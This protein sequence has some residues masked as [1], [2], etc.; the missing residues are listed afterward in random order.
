MDDQIIY[1][2]EMAQIVVLHVNLNSQI[3]QLTKAL[4][5][6]RVQL[7]ESQKTLGEV[8]DPEESQK[9]RERRR[10][11]MNHREM[12]QTEN[13]R[14]ALMLMKFSKQPRKRESSRSIVDRVDE[15]W[16]TE[17]L[18]WIVIDFEKERLF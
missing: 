5:E 14:K 15:V 1:G 9:L 6:A 4:K 17:K 16:L 18:I 11:A 7:A 10:R 2:K 3:G 8:E 12:A 13:R